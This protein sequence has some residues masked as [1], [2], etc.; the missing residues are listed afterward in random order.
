M[1]LD[2]EELEIRFT[3]HPPNES[4]IVDFQAIRKEARYFATLINDVCPD[5]REKSMAII[6]VE[7]AV[8]WANAGIARR[9]K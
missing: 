2:K 9:G 1:P 5:C 8:M 7:E 6:S 3:H 4:Q